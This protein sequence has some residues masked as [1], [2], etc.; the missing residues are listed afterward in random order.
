MT[1]EM[2]SSWVAEKL[3]GGAAGSW[4]GKAALSYPMRERLAT[5]KQPVLVLRPRDELWAA[6]VR[7]RE[8]LPGAKCVDLADRGAGV[9]DVAAHQV[10]AV[11]REFLGR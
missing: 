6:T 11:A 10:A 4:A 5:V 3:S 1:L 2:L 8:A 9:F 7:A